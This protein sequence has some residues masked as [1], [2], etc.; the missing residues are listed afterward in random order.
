MKILLYSH[1]DDPSGDMLYKLIKTDLPEIGM[2]VCR[3]AISKS[4][5]ELGGTI[6]VC[7]GGGLDQ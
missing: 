4:R 2:E 6:H 7:T 1:A 5:I 3:K